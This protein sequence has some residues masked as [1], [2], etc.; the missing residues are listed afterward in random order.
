MLD[1][2]RRAEHQPVSFSDLRAG[3]ID[4]P[5]A[6]VSEL[7]LSG[8]AIDRV[9]RS[10]RFVGVRLLDPERVEQPR[11]SFGR[12]RARSRRQASSK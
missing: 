8:F 7:E 6:V 3:G 11:D 4:F 1:R 5:A 12:R 2:L 9:Y 10:G